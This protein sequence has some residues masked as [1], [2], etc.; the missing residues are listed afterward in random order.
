MP[1]D[2]RYP[3]RPFLAASVATFRDGRVLIATRGRP[4]MEACWSLPGGLVEPG[5]SLHE[6]AL[7]ELREE[8]G[9]EAEIAAFVDH[10]EIIERDA[11]GVVHHFVIA[12][13]AARWRAGEPAPGPEAGAVRWALPDE[14]AQ[15]WTTPGLAAI[16]TRAAAVLDGGPR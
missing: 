5:E 15:L 4:P 7:R 3:A 6:A 16:V 14:V 11:T 12:A 9:V 10:V 2:R 1:E 8:V 13:F